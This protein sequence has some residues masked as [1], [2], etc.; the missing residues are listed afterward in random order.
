MIVIIVLPI[1]ISSKI[2]R[3]RMDEDFY[4]DGQ[5]KGTK[6]SEGRIYDENMNIIGNE[7]GDGSFYDY[8]TGILWRRI[9]RA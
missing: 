7:Q 6:D 3:S 2:R 4:Q 1:I 9:K 8:R 5:F